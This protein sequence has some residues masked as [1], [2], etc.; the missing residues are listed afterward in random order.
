MAGTPSLRIVVADDSRFM[1]RL[2][3]DALGARGFDVVA[4]AEDGDRRSP[5]AAT[6]G[7]TS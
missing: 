6:T 2:L 7:P 1:R 4:V 3:S 5:P